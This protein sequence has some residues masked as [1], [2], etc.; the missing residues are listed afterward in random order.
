[1]S[2]RDAFNA[3]AQDYDRLRP[4]LIPCF[5]DFYGVA[6]RLLGEP[7][8]APLRVLDLGAGTGLMS[9]FVLAAFP[10]ARLTLVDVS[11]DMLALAR[12]RFTG[13]PNVEFRAADY[14]AAG[15]GEGWDAIV[16]ALSIHHLPHDA[17]RDLF[18]RVARALVPG[19]VFVN[20]EQVL[21]ETPAIEARQ[22]AWWH[23]EIRRRGAT[24][25]DVAQALERMRHD[26]MATAGDQLTWMVEAGL[27]EVH[28]PYRCHRFAVLTGRR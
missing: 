18:G 12:K 20:A 11:E 23:R 16:S 8:P 26:I 5:D 10:N 1:M 25:H 2:V 7:G 13:N 17:K 14:A 3:S 22:E 9:L 19:G 28:S 24:E 4:A 27:T 6:V 15:L 21:G